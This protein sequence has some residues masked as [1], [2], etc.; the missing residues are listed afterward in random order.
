MPSRTSRPNHTLP[1][2]LPR[3]WRFPESEIAGTVFFIFVYI[4]ARAVLHA[5]EIP[6]GEFAVAGKFCDAKVIRTILSAVGE[7]FFLKISDELRHFR[8]VI[9]GANQLRLLDVERGCVFEE[10]FFVFRRVLL[11]A[12]AVAGGI[13]D[14]FIVHVSD[15]HDVF[16]FVSTLAQKALE[17]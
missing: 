12:D 2:S 3:F 16:D 5:S 10:R 1:E 17:N 11:Y 14:D 15:V 9:G 7:S 4:D 13:A 6:F 8:N